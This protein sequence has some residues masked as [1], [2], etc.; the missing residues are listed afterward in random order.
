[1]RWLRNLN[2]PAYRTTIC[3]LA[4][5]SVPRRLYAQHLLESGALQN[6]FPSS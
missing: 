4:V 3:P 1:M 2:E 6:W 5:W